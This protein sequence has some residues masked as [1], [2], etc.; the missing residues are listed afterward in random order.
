M[1]PRVLLN[2]VLL[3]LVRGQPLPSWVLKDVENEY[4]PIT[5]PLQAPAGDFLTLLTKKKNTWRVTCF[6]QYRE[7]LTGEDPQWRNRTAGRKT[8]EL[9]KSHQN[10]W[11]KHYG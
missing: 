4:F 10:S 1:K 2:F 6:Q 11:K 9:P 8:C 5:K 3:L 7:I